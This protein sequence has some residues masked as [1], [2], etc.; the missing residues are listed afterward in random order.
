MARN[1]AGRNGEW[2]SAL[3]VAWVQIP[4]IWNIFRTSAEQDD[5]AAEFRVFWPLS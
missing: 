4:E 5:A 1:L 3:D 2:E